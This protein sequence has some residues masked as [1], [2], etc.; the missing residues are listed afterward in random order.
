MN[1]KKVIVAMSGGVDSSVVA[2]LLK[3]K[4][5]YVTGVFLKFW[6][7]RC[8]A[9]SKNKCCSSES[10]K[11]VRKVAKILNIPFYVFDCSEEFKK[12]VVDYFIKEYKLGNTPN[13]CVVCNKKIKFGFLF[14]KIKAIGGDYLA[15]GHYVKNVKFRINN[16]KSEYKIFRAEDK[17]KDQSYFLYNLNQKKLAQLLFPISSYKK[18]E[19]RKLAKKFKLPVA[20]IKESQDVC[21]LPKEG[22]EIFLKKYIKNIKPGLIVNTEGRKI[23]NHQGLPFYTIGQR[24]GIG[25]GGGDAYYVIK[26]NIKENKL[27][28][29]QDLNDKRIFIKQFRTFDMNWV[30][31]RKMNFPLM[32]DC[33][34]R[35]RQKVVRVKILKYNKVKKTGLV[36]FESSEKAVT[37]GQSAVFYNKEELLGGGIIK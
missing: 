4:G 33:Q 9:N 23:G 36:E 13:P 19:V 32:A 6:Q 16:L 20:E 25:I 28:V 29:T 30:S 15:T 10:L 2:A 1:R 35:Y 31:E 37:S 27:I 12:Q 24:K 21:F 8:L 34:M 7:D 5:Y 17:N 18:S 11:R 22:L 26:K 3:N 14:N